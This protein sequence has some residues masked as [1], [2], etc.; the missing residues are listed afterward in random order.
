MCRLPA[1]R[2]GVAGRGGEA[3]GALPGDAVTTENQM[4]LGSSL[5]DRFVDK[6]LL[7]LGGL[8]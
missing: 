3:A 4:P 6:G 5:H 8:P 1:L 7:A 2:L